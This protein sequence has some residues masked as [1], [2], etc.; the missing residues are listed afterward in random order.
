MKSWL[1]YFQHNRTHRRAIAS[2]KGIRVEPHLRS[3]L[4]RSLQRFQIGET[5]EGIHLKQ[6]AAATGDA[7]YAEAIA[8]FIAEEQQHAQML[9][10]ILKIMGAAP[11]TSHWSDN[12]FMGVRH[13]MGLQ[14]ELVVLLSAEMIAKRYYRALYEGTQDELLRSLF[15]QI[16][17]DEEG[18]IAFHCA[19]LQ[20]AWSQ[21]TPGQRWFV[22]HS[23]RAFYQVVCV[24]VA[25]DHR[26]LLRAVGLSPRQ[27]LRDCN[28]VFTRTMATIFGVA[29]CLAPVRQYSVVVTGNDPRQPF[30]LSS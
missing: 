27:F 12:V 28:A 29:L 20:N 4:I 16:C 5:G 18:H 24:V 13:L 9:A 3:P 11:L 2:E 30:T 25:W 17:D 19:F 23:W 14:L 15:A 8:L 21:R 7:A 26:S 22:Q 10:G 6:G 1:T